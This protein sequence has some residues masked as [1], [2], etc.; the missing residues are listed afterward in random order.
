MK[1]ILI[2]LCIAVAMFVCVSSVQGQDAWAKFA[3][4]GGKFSILM[5]GEPKPQIQTAD[6]P[7]G[8]YTTYLYTAV[9]DGTLYLVGWVDYDRSFIFGVQAEINANRD[10]FIKGVKGTLI[11]E[12]SIT[13]KGGY[14]GLEF[15][16]EMSADRIALSKVYVVGRRPYQL[17]AV[18][19]KGSDLT[20]VNKFFSS[21]VITL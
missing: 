2:H 18:T 4:E 6:S 8:P 10:N 14:P 19:K 12:K 7:N 9:A 11:T 3:P 16:A 5:P 20:N 13:L 15:T 17:I 21:F 1:K